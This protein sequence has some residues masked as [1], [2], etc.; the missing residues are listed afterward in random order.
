[1]YIA[2]SAIITKNIKTSFDGFENFWEHKTAKVLSIASSF[3][4]LRLTCARRL[5]A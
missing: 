5:H 1:M 2:Y 3:A 4:K